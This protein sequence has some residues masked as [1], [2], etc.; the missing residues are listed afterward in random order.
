MSSAISFKDWS[1]GDSYMVAQTCFGE[2][3]EV[4]KKKNLTSFQQNNREF[5]IGSSYEWQNSQVFFII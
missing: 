2:D 1:T 4:Q 3:E 5:Q